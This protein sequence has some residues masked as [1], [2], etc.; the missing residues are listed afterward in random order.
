MLRGSTSLKPDA[1]SRGLA[2][3]KTKEHSPSLLIDTIRQAPVLHQILD[4]DQLD[5]DPVDITHQAHGD[6]LVH[7]PMDAVYLPLGYP[8]GFFA[9]R[10]NFATPAGSVLVGLG[11]RMPMIMLRQ[12]SL[13]FFELGA[14]LMH[15]RE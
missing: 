11:F 9:D 1:G 3:K 14:I 5:G 2:F 6:D 15:G 12:L 10:L 4:E 8:G 13:T 7:Q